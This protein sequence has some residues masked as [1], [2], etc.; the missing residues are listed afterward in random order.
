MLANAAANN[1]SNWIAQNGLTEVPTGNNK[2]FTGLVAGDGGAAY[3]YGTGTITEF[4][5]IF[6]IVENNSSGS[7]TGSAAITLGELVTISSVKS[8]TAANS[9]IKVGIVFQAASDYIAGNFFQFF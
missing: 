1:G 8:G 3:H 6:G 2:N 4:D 9:T 7:A 5:G